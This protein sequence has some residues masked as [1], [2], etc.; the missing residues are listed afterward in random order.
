M[1]PA[2]L[3]P[4]FRN[5]LALH[6]GFRRLKFTPDEIFLCPMDGEIGVTVR[7][8]DRRA[9]F[10]A[11]PWNA[12]DEIMGPWGAAVSW[13]NNEATREDRIEVWDSS[14]AVKGGVWIILELSR[15]GLLDMF[16][17]RDEDEPA[18]LLH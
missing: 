8:G 12:A 4:S 16:T 5:A 2:D 6:E 14:H 13:W 17:F 7:R 10:L 9:N 3:H 18:E 11:G 1:I 15:T